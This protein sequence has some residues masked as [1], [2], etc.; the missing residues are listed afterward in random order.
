MWKKLA[1]FAAGLAIGGTAGY[2]AGKYL[3]EDKALAET[4]KQVS[5]IKQYYEARLTATE[6]AAELNVLK[7]QYAETQILQAQTE[8]ESNPVDYTK[9]KP[10]QSEPDY[11]PD[12]EWG[13]AKRPKG[14][15]KRQQKRRAPL[16]ENPPYYEEQDGAAIY[17][18]E[19][20][21][22]PVIISEQ[23][24]ANEHFEFEKQTL[25]WFTGDNV[26]TDEE[27]NPLEDLSLIG[28]EW[29]DAFGGEED[30]DV[31]HVRNPKISCDYEI[32]RDS[33]SYR[34]LDPE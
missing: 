7:Q 28:G 19:P 32:I 9:I 21:S 2:F 1:W 4:E 20:N 10:K 29:Q 25:F 13:D 23:A 34:T 15:P 6:K 5:E 30:P 33:R 22:E 11:D 24:Y 17:P 27:Y 26:V 16:A 3:T 12:D 18:T 8:A 31:V 14:A